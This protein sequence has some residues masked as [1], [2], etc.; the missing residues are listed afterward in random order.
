MGSNRN[1]EK[2]V[3]EAITDVLIYHTAYDYRQFYRK[4]LYAN[5][6]WRW[7]EQFGEGIIKKV[8]VTDSKVLDVIDWCVG[9]LEE[10]TDE[11]KALRLQFARRN[12]TINDA[13]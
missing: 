13:E 5:G 1:I 9:E 3:I 7:E 11:L 2:K 10:K 12:D 8:P 4:Y 6:I